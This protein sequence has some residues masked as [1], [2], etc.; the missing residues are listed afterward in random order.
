MTFPLTFTSSVEAEKMYIK[1]YITSGKLVLQVYHVLH[2]RKDVK[3]SGRCR[4]E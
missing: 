3:P 4:C 1:L 2:E